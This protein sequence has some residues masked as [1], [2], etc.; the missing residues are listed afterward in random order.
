MESVEE[1]GHLVDVILRES[2]AD[3]RGGRFR[4]AKTDI[5]LA[6]SYR[7]HGRVFL[8]ETSRHEA[9]HFGAAGECEGRVGTRTWMCRFYGEAPHPRVRLREIGTAIARQ[10]S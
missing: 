6:R 3:C 10:T 8:T 7:R 2:R 1:G 5:S 4:A 9:A